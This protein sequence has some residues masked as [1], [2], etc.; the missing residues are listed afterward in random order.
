MDC[1]QAQ[2]HLLGADTSDALASHLAACADCRALAAKVR[3]LDEA[4]RILPVPPE[5]AAARDAFLRQLQ[6]AP[7]STPVPLT[8]MWRSWLPTSPMR[9]RPRRGLRATWPRLAVAASVLLCL[10]AGV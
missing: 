7:A 1:E 8:P 5:S 3:R 10:S 6:P 9:L 4:A 2:N